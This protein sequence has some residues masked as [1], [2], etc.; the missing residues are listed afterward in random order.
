MMGH[1]VGTGYPGKSEADSKVAFGLKMPSKAVCALASLLAGCGTAS[2]SQEQSAAAEPNTMTAHI[3]QP[4]TNV[5]AY[6]FAVN[7]C[8]SAGG[9]FK[10]PIDKGLASKVSDVFECTPQ[11][12]NDRLDM[13]KLPVPPAA[14]AEVG[15]LK[16]LY[17]TFVKPLQALTPPVDKGVS[18]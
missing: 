14:K 6:N 8:K 13:D 9:E 15:F 10:G 2:D 16:K 11:A 4:A 7:T 1:S 17:F 5:I 12:G 3:N 18:F